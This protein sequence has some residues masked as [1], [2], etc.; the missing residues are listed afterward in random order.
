MKETGDEWTEWSPEERRALDALP[1]GERPSPDVEERIVAALESRGLLDGGRR[2]PGGVRAW[3]AL[4][5]T[6]AAAAAVVLI[7]AGFAAGRVSAARPIPAD[8][9][10]RFALFLLRGSDRPAS[11]AA[12]EQARVEEY[13]RW[14]RGLAASGRRIS[15]EKLADDERL[16][17]GGGGGEDPGSASA[18][19]EIRGFFVV[20]ATDLADAVEVARTCPHL[21]HGGRILVRPI[22]PT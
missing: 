21:R 12:G 14:A 10:P 11:S 1:N 9:S 7:A 18:P 4:V 3:R 19:A 20:A 8:G 5:A 13:R 15:G 6:A 17:S 22:S 16:V 2:R